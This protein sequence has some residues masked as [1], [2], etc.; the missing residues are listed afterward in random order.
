MAPVVEAEAAVDEVERPRVM[1]EVV[2]RPRESSISG[3]V[4]AEE[5]RSRSRLV[6]GGLM[7]LRLLVKGLRGVADYFVPRGNH[8]VGKESQ[9]EREEREYCRTGISQTRIVGGTAIM[10]LGSA[11]RDNGLQYANAREAYLAG[12]GAR[13]AK[14]APA[15]ARKKV[16]KGVA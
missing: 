10:L 11:F 12:Y 14:K 1:L 5:R 2:G 9:R 3:W 6:E 15:K 13:D 16:G 7:L 4:L 8:P